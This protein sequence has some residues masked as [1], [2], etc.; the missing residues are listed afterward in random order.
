I[1][2]DLSIRFHFGSDGA[3]AH[4][5]WW[6]DDIQL[7]L[8]IEPE[9]PVD[10]TAEV[11]YGGAWLTW[12]TPP[13]RDDPAY[14]EELL[15]YKIFRSTDTENDFLDTLITDNQYLDYLVGQ[16][17]GEYYYIVYSIYTTQEVMSE[18]VAIEWTQDVEFEENT[19]PDEWE[20]SGV[21]PNPFNSTARI[22]YNVP[23]QGSV[24]LAIYDL[25]GRQLA[26]LANGIHQPGRHQAM[27]NAEDWT[28]GIYIV[29]MTTP[30]GTMAT[31]LVLIR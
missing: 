9:A 27:L 1:D 8:K 17:A 10:L 23:S 12:T 20:L 2:Q 13:V 30:V 16:S 26:M 15:G 3:D 14:P 11:A 24:H 18:G 7:R 4:R 29:R 22:A 25:S 28:S 5:G 19:L 21:Y 31:R 6:I